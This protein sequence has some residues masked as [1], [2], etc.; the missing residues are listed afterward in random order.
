[1]MEEL[2]QKTGGAS[3]RL[4]PKD[5]ELSRKQAADIVRAVRSHYVLTL[6]GDSPPGEKFKLTVNR[7][8]KLFVSYLPLQ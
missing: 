3:F 1:M 7:P 2:A 4:N 8:D 6:A 5:Q